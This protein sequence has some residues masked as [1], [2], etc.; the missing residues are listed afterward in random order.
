MTRS[1]SSA[2]LLEVFDR[3]PRARVLV[4]GDLILDRYT[5]GNA[6]RLSPEAPVVVLHAGE[7]EDRLGGAAN[8]AHMLQALDA[9]VL[10]AGVVGSDAPGAALRSLLNAQQIDTSAILTDATRP[11]TL[12]E[13]FLGKAAARHSQQIL[14]VD[15]ES[16]DAL[17]EQLEAE[18]IQRI[19][20]MLPEV[21]A[22]LVSDYGKGVCSPRLLRAV[23]DGGRAA[24]VPV[25]VDPIRA[26]DY[27]P[28]RGATLLTP[29]R[30]EAEMASGHKVRAPEDAFGAAHDLTRRLG[31]EATVVT[32]DSD[33]MVV[34]WADGREQHFATRKR[35]VYDITGAG[36]MVLAM[37]GACLAG[38]ADIA[39]AV[40]L[41]NVAGGLEVE[42]VGVVALSREEIRRDLILTARTGVGKLVSAA[43]I[44][45][46]SAAARSRGQRV[47]FTNG[48]FD[49]LH[50]G[51]VAGLAEAASQGDRLV[52]GLNSDA[53]VRRLKGP[54]RP[55]IG[56][57]ERAAML[58][59]LSSVDYVVLFDDE[60]PYDLIL[61]VRPDVLVKGVSYANKRIA[62]QEFVESYGGRVHLA[63]EVQGWS[64]TSLLERL[65]ATHQRHAA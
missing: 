39:D 41:G 45:G 65:T 18:L 32:L 23:I 28:Y 52:V 22:V 31:L 51:H 5:W 29:N 43:D 61:Q 21:G 27:G 42:H 30:I 54:Q 12:K 55:V 13:R 34:C 24:G 17:D 63:C 64:T 40:R 15:T 58:A 14:R 2:A 56:Q 33:G 20:A 47:V 62:G 11:T 7:R 48:C 36:D 53:S 8:V 4:V 46:L 25:L 3:L 44:A 26:R 16:R 60:T 59:A 6:E 38:G 37:L 19:Q 1:M 49:L 50:A 57:A 10:C 9:E 35:A